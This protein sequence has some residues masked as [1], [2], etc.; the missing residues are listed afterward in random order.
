MTGDKEAIRSILHE[1]ITIMNLA[2][3]YEAIQ[4]ERRR[5]RG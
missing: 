3:D 5:A 2:V 4:E 1:H